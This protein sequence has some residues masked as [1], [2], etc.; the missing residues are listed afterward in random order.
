MRL[1]VKTRPEERRHFSVVLV[2]SHLC[3]TSEGP[4]RAR[5]L[6][7]HPQSQA[8]PLPHVGARV[9]SRRRSRPHGGLG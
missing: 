4:A 7:N 1:T 5:E 3:P 2:D 6:I 9:A 8:S